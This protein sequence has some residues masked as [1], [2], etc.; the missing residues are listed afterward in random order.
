MCLVF[1]KILG[2]PHT[3][4][5]PDDE[6]Y[7]VSLT[8]SFTMLATA[9][10]SDT[11]VILFVL[12]QHRAQQRPHVRVTAISTRGRRKILWLTTEASA[13]RRSRN[14]GQNTCKR[15]SKPKGLNDTTAQL[16]TRTSDLKFFLRGWRRVTSVLLYSHTSHLSQCNQLST[17]TSFVTKEHV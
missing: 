8:F 3:H 5:I 10:F 9:N 7:T 6:P 16:A 11:L 2:L 1:A 4:I 13:G 15:R 17:Y 14:G 12:S